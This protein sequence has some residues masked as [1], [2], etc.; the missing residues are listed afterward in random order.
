MLLGGAHGGGSERSLSVA[1]LPENGGPAA[2]S[3]EVSNHVIRSQEDADMNSNGRLPDGPGYPVRDAVNGVFDYDEE[4]MAILKSVANRLIG[5]P[6]VHKLIQKL[7]FANEAELCSQRGCDSLL[8]LILN[9]GDG[10][11][12]DNIETLARELHPNTVGYF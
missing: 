7:G 5:E 6:D 8:H 2:R 4:D 10:S 1:A 12:L 3:G 9:G 11:P